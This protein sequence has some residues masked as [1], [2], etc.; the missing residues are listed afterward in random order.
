MCALGAA[1]RG[2]ERLEDLVLEHVGGALVELVV[3]SAHARQRER[4]LVDRHRKIVQ[5]L[6]ARIVG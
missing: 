4:K 6:G 1:I 2:L 3:R 5:Q